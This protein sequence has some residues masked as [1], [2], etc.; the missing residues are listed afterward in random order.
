MRKPK[1]EKKKLNIIAL[2]GLHEV[3]KNMTVLEYGS[4]MII[5][6]CG[7]TFPNSDMLGIDCVIPDFTYVI[8]NAERIRGL[9]I[10]H[11]HEDHIGGVP[12]LLKDVNVPIYA[13]PLVQGLLKIKFKEH[14]I[15][16]VKMYDLEECSTYDLGCFRIEPIHVTHSVADSFALAIDTPVGR[17]FHTGDFKFDY[18]PIDGNPTDIARLAELGNEGI[19]LLLADS[20]NATR[21]GFSDSEKKIKSSLADIFR[22]N[23]KRII[24]TTFSSN[25]HRIQSVMDL[26]AEN[27]RKVAVTGRSMENMVKVAAELGYLKV[28]SNTLIPLKQSK[29]YSGSELVILTTGS[30]GE[31]SSALS[32][33]AMGQH[34]DVKITKND[35]VI[36]SSSIVPG[37]D[38]GVYDLINSLMAAGA[39]VIYTENAK[40]HASGHARREELKLMHALLKPQ[41]FMPIHGEIR[42]LMSHA[43]LAEEMGM[44]PKNIV[45]SENGSIV[46]LYNDRIRISEETVP[47]GAIL[48]DGLGIGDVGTSVLSE[49]RALSTSGLLV[50]SAV[51][52]NSNR[53]VSDIQLHSRGFIYVKNYGQLLDRA[54]AELY[55]AL[56]DAYEDNKSKEEI[57]QILIDKL[58]NFIYK[59][60]NR[61]PVIV[62]VFMEV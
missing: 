27:G 42:L 46:E 57:K 49:R 40:V 41:F 15:T 9:I 44:D 30:Q 62:P 55:N 58:K 16:N 60:I 6:D 61:S 14:K 21:E 34:K 33:I 4:D 36:L 10:T 52:D 47:A 12:Y 8:E 51:F 22:G 3:G 7:M 29:Q 37:N 54:R 39:E 11:A 28:P 31:A 45:I 48:V 26:A 1:K 19:K 43:Q 32:R 13:S 18:T 24:V 35:I 50:I 17:I 20:T 53:I 38:I 59:N 25:I 56:E 23:T 2:G 5:I